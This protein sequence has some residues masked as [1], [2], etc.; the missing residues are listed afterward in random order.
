MNTA[1]PSPTVTASAVLS[2]KIA[3]YRRRKGLKQEELGALVGVSAQ[4]V[5]KW[6]NGGTPDVLL[7]PKIA[8]VLDVTVND[9][10]AF[11]DKT[12]A[13][14]EIPTKSALLDD[15]FRYCKQTF[16]EDPSAVFSF[17]FDTAWTIIQGYGT[18]DERKDLA[19][20]REKYRDLPKEN[21]ISSKIL[22]DAGTI[23]L[24]HDPKN[25]FLCVVEDTEELSQN[26]IEN[27]RLR[28]FLESFGDPD[29]FRLLLFTQSQ[30]ERDSTQY[31]VD[32]LADELGLSSDKTKSLC[33][34][35]VKYSLMSKQIVHLNRSKMDVYNIMRNA[36]IRPMLMLASWACTGQSMMNLYST[37]TRTEPYIKGQ[38]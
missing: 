4:A 32:F 1:K 24:S 30:T 37:N 12:P 29:F 33:E 5:S 8:E 14:D 38:F 6:E 19:E 2:E 21:R 20:I 34:K 22:T 11:P 9:L 23:H 15:L 3:E 27:E 25:P 31:T 17:L 28:E 35:C 36:Y 13:P 26:L 7:L 16:P 10:F 18:A